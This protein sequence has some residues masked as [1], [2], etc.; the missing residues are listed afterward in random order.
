LETE[1]AVAPPPKRSVADID[2]S[3]PE[4]PSIAVLPFINMSSD[5][6][7]EYFSDGVSEDIITEL[8]RF[9]SLFIIARNSTFIYKGRAVDVRTLSKELGVRY[10]L[11]GSI[12]RSTDRI[13]VTAQ[14]IDALMGSHIWAER[15]DRVVQDIFA[16]QEEIT[17][18]IVSVIAPEI[19]AAEVARARRR[20][21]SLSAYEIAVRASANLQAAWNN[22]DAALR[23]QALREAEHALA[24][25]PESA[26]ALDTLAQ[27]HFQD[28]YFRTTSDPRLSW[29]KGLAA[30]QRAIGLDR[31]DSV[32][33]W[34]KGLLLWIK[35]LVEFLRASPSDADG[36]EDRFEEALSA[37]RHARSLNPCHAGTLAV[38]G[39]LETAAGNPEQGIE[40]L[41]QGLRSI[42]RDPLRLDRIAFL[43]LAYFAMKDY[44]NGVE[45]AQEVV[46]D[47]PNNFL[48]R[49]L[50]AMN[51]VGVG[52]IESAREQLDEA[53][54]LS[55]EALQARLDGYTPL[56]RPEDGH[57]QT[58]FMRIAAGLEDPS[59]VV[60]LR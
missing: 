9:H 60:A 38:L 36:C 12:R 50:L 44:S 52:R 54:R 2:L 57:R 42:P 4:R 33:Y 7:Q 58:V 45:A 11:E 34:I 23:L 27:V 39:L 19:E 29:N 49:M 8:S 3:L 24:I 17:Q 47:A 20:P 35:G 22:V 13:R 25:D 18:S 51:Y 14:L 59:A 48:G 28:V 30:A 5:P 6:E 16:V 32:A 10:V 55:S 56:R 21:N 43:S 31:S 37:M 1:N 41:N 46:R 40:Y 15:Y 26:L 53:R